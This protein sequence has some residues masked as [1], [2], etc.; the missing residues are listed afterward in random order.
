MTVPFAP[1]P[2][3]LN[4]R[5]S[6]ALHRYFRRAHHRATLGKYRYVHVMNNGIH[7]AGI[8]EFINR[9]FDPSQHGFVFPVT[10]WAT[11]ERLRG[12][13]HVHQFDLD[14]LDSDGDYRIIVHGL[15]SDEAVA[16]LH[17]RPQ[18]LKKCYWFVWG[19]DLYSV[20]D[21]EAHHAVRRG[22]AGV[23]TSF[24]RDVYTAK[25]GSTRFFDVAYPHEMTEDMIVPGSVPRIPGQ[26][27][28]QINNS[29]DETT[30]EMLEILGRFRDENIKITT[31]LSYISHKQ[32]D[33]R[34]QIL[35]SGQEIFGHSFNPILQFMSLPEYA[36]H[37]ASVDVY[38]SNQNRQQGNGN[39]AFICSLGGKVFVKSDTPVYRK[40]ADAGIRYFDTH[41]IAGMSFQQ[42][43][44]RDAS[45]RE[46]TMAL[47]KERMS[48][49]Y[50]VRQWG[51]MFD[52]LPP[53]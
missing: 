26:L 29:A 14:S 52:A 2:P 38:I 3:P 6:G 40:Y 4:E 25:Y 11:R 20:P 53:R 21:D 8:V 37:L 7:S 28:V 10:T 1:A 35:R 51:A 9:N 45:E 30:L 36:T 16:F 19:G 17:Q 24:D 50:K 27:H 31:I 18:L 43:T 32:D 46:Q 23:I 12:L 22:F 49:A 13:P 15:F 5:V 47:L 33:R 39:A 34:L 48:E 44:A 41:D 42:L